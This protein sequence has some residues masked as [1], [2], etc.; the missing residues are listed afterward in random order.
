MSFNQLTI[1]I[2]CIPPLY[3]LHHPLLCR[4]INPYFFFTTYLFLVSSSCVIVFY[5]PIYIDA[6]FLCVILRS[7]S[8]LSSFSTFCVLLFSL[9]CINFH[10]PSRVSFSLTL[11]YF[12]LIHILL[13]L[14]ISTIIGW[15]SELS[16]SLT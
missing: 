7:L 10:D 2:S 11:L 13:I 12:L 14:I 4:N 15:W 5:P 8:H 3:S 6:A 1:S 9:I 16:L